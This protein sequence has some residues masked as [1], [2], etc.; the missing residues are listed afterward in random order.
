MR[1]PTREDLR[2]RRGLLVVAAVM[3]ALVAVW[4]LARERPTAEVA[5]AGGGGATT[6]SST[7]GPDPSVAAPS[8]TTTT[9][10]GRFV[11]SLATGQPVGDGPLRP[12]RVEV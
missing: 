3:V 2:R 9:P 4:G 1:T 6:P 11:A 10:T 12:S 8:P 5:D 7:A